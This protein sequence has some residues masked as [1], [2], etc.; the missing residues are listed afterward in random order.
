ML[1]FLIGLLEAA[2][3]FAISRLFEPPP[4]PVPQGMIGDD[5]INT[6][7]NVGEGETFAG[8]DPTVWDTDSNSDEP[9]QQETEVPP[10]Q[11]A[12]QTATVPDDPI[13]L[14]QSDDPERQEQ[15]G[16]EKEGDNE[17]DGPPDP[18]LIDSG[19]LTDSTDEVR[20]PEQGIDSTDLE[21]RTPER[22]EAVDPVPWTLTSVIEA[23][24]EELYDRMVEA[25]QQWMQHTQ[26]V[27]GWDVEELDLQAPYSTDYLENVGEQI[28]LE[29]DAVSLYGLQDGDD[30]LRYDQYETEID[31]SDSFTSPTQLLSFSDV[32][33][34]I[35]IDTLLVEFNIVG[36][37][38]V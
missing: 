14:D 15:I 16:D 22:V 10:I 25:E 13:N 28:T 21:Y 34:G 19:R 1:A 17:D 8:G 38:D 18:A 33:G 9:E 12:E 37:D 2:I 29:T 32:L 24:K 3:D 7:S 11:T 27:F 20:Y 4:D 5:P 36:Q 30:D 23:F 26:Y 31:D 35:D 6:Y